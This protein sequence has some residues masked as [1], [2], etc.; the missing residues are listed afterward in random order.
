MASST[1]TAPIHRDKSSQRF[2][3]MTATPNNHNVTTPASEAGVVAENN[4]VM[5]EGGPASDITAATRSFTL[6]TPKCGS[7]TSLSEVSRDEGFSDTSDTSD[8]TSDETFDRMV[9]GIKTYGV[10]SFTQDLMRLTYVLQGSR[11]RLLENNVRLGEE[12]RN[13]AARTIAGL[14]EENSG[15]KEENRRLGDEGIE[16]EADVMLT[17]E[18]VTYDTWCE[19]S[20]RHGVGRVGFYSPRS[21]ML[22]GGGRCEQA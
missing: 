22:M 10:N 15:L 1:E 6:G 4:V 14:L 11:I 13:R 12:S 19:R 9:K 5:A 8:T 7:S 2:S 21:P 18:C 16:M 20:P 3:Q 17:T